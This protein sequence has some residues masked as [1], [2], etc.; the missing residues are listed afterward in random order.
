MLRLI[1]SLS[2]MHRTAKPLRQAWEKTKPRN[3]LIISIRGRDADHD[4]AGFI[5]PPFFLQPIGRAAENRVA[6][7]RRGLSHF[8]LLIFHKAPFA[9][10]G[11]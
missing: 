9:T 5:G 2:S 3:G 7:R 8:P 6:K 1:V 11:C 10:S 4:R